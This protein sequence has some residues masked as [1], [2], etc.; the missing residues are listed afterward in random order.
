[1]SVGDALLSCV[2]PSLRINRFGRLARPGTDRLRML[3]MRDVELPEF[4]YCGA[5]SQYPMIE[6]RMGR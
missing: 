4:R 3:G 2:L 1:M 5:G 6:V